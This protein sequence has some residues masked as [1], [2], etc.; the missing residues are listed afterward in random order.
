[1]STD[2][3]D[4]DVTPAHRPII[5]AACHDVID[6]HLPLSWQRDVTVHEA[7]GRCV[8]Q[9][10]MKVEQ[11]DNDDDE[12]IL[13]RV[14][15]DDRATASHVSTIDVP[16]GRRHS[17][18]DHHHDD[19][20]DDD[21]DDMQPLDLTQRHVTA[22]N[23][24]SPSADPGLSSYTQILLLKGERYEIM[25]VGDGRWISRNEYE[26]IN[27]LQNG[28]DHRR[29]LSLTDDSSSDRPHS[30]SDCTPPAHDTDDK[31]L[32]DVNGNTCDVSTGTSR[33]GQED[34]KTV[35]CENWS[36]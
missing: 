36:D 25:P 19:D 33:D 2:S 6:G 35:K 13:G 12:S 18:P 4:S 32:D 14:Q 7:A 29:R 15:Q 9:V 17:P 8:S 28:A 3:T 10:A 31:P 21:D 30:N 24:S 11:T 16:Q 23:T 26:L 34:D 22:S 20:D 27:A 1:M 5:V